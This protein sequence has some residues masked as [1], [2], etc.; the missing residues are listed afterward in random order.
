MLR[1][2]LTR[3]A[4]VLA[5][6]EGDPRGAADELRAQLPPTHPYPLERARAL[7]ALA[8][9]ERRARRRAAAR[10]ALHAARE[11]F[12]AAHCLPWLAHTDDRLAQLDGRTATGT[13][14]P[15]LTDLERRIVTL[16]RGGASNRQVAAA[17]HVSVKSVEAAL[18]RLYRRLGVRD[19]AG[20]LA[21][22]AAG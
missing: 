10:T 4:A 6:A 19:R 17:L 7:L 8:D 21:S 5:G 2:G 18:T 15:A 14:A 22:P 9:L 12:A 1:L 13:A 20:L 11:V 3:A 16:V